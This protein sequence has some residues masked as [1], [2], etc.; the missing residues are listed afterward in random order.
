MTK[1]VTKIV[2]S[3]GW[4]IVVDPPVPFRAGEPIPASLF[5]GTHP[6]TAVRMIEWS[7]FDEATD[8]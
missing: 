3:D 5:L 4:I 8:D 2:L 6:I 1:W 7:E